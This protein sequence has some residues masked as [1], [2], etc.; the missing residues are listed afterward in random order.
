MK[1]SIV[2][3]STQSL[4]H[5]KASIHQQINDRLKLT[6]RHHDLKTQI[7]TLHGTTNEYAL[8]VKNQRVKI[9]TYEKLHDKW[10]VNIRIN[11]QRLLNS[12]NRIQT[13]TQHIDKTKDF[14]EYFNQFQI[15]FKPKILIMYH[16]FNLFLQQ[17][18]VKRFFSIDF[19]EI[20]SL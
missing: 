10:I 14:L 17:R 4:D 6:I 18:F 9:F 1:H 20:S 3:P 7:H 12:L 11:R 5:L 2:V 8:L 15:E 19:N 13:L 16:Q